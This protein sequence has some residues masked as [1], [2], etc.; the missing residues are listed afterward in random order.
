MSRTAS[1]IF[2]MV[3]YAIFFATF[4]YLIVFVGDL[5][6]GTRTVDVGPAAPP[7]VAALIDVALIALFGVQHSVMARPRFKAWWTKIVPK[8]IERSVYVLAASIALMILFRFWRPIDAIVWDVRG[9]GLSQLIWLLFWAGWAMVL[10]STFLINHFELFGVQQA[11]LHCWGRECGEP[12]LRQP[13]FYKWIAHPLYSGFFL[14][15]WAAP[16][17]TVGHLL[18]AAG[19]SL[20]ML[21]AIRY[22]ERDLA[23]LFGQDYRNYRA[24]VG[25]LIPRFGRKPAA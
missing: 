14:A 12:E 15:F 18:L 21:V 16:Q 20:Y 11:W 17:M 7:L 8:P 4:L 10:I 22:E 5:S 25:M 1:L 2:A 19:V 9:P 3:V 23:N 24:G 6:F 13:F